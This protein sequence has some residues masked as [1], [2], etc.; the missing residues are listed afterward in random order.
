MA[1]LKSDNHRHISL[2]E[3]KQEFGKLKS[4][5]NGLIFP[6]LQNCFCYIFEDGK[7]EMTC[8]VRTDDPMTGAMLQESE[9]APGFHVEWEATAEQVL[10]CASFGNVYDVVNGLIEVQDDDGNKY[11]LPISDDAVRSNINDESR[12]MVQSYFCI[13]GA[14]V[15]EQAWS[16]YLSEQPKSFKKELEAVMSPLEKAA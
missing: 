2:F 6:E 11:Q 7:A 13:F 4:I 1:N 9:N 8:F 3:L 5:P 12:A 16:E 10:D 14:D 15:V